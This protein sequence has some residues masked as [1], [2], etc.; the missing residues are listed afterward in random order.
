M[1]TEQERRHAMWGAV[2][3]VAAFTLLIFGCIVAMPADGK[4]RSREVYVGQGRY[5][6]AGERSE[7]RRFEAEQRARN[8]EHDY[9]KRRLEQ[10]EREERRR[11]EYRLSR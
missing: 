5:S 10:A 3:L 4:E 9:Y 7:C 2:G 8:E 1:M 6:C 11:D